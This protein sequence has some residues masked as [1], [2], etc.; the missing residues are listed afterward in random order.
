MIFGK[1]KLLHSIKFTLVKVAMG[2][3]LNIFNAIESS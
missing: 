2:T 1:E 3:I